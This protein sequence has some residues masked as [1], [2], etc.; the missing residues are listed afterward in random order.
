MCLRYSLTR[1]PTLADYYEVVADAA[2]GWSPRYN[3]A[4][5]S[6]MPVITQRTRCTLEAL[7]FGLVR[8]ARR[9]AERPL[10]L[11]NARAETL[12]AKP[13]FREAALHCRCLVPADG[14]YEWQKSGAARLPHYFAL[15]TG[16]PFF[17]AGLWEPAQDDM[18]AAFC[19]V[20]TSPNA[21]LQ[22]IHDR[23]PVILG[24]NSGPAWLGDQPLDPAQLAR[25]CQPL[26]AERMTGH[27]VDSRV[28][29]VRYEAPDC[30]APV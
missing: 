20:T 28:N 18:P 1:H 5:T 4:L 29:N 19:I 24:P 22:P 10:I 12:L 2:D 17:F 6:R 26:P 23:M 25:L 13:S 3:V 30:L 15:K 7:S 11:G 21:L 9:P 16:Q 8:P 27:R 14:F